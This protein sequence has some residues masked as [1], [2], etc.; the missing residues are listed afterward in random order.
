MVVARARADA[1]AAG[2]RRPDG[3]QLPQALH[4][5]TSASTPDNLMTMRHAA[6][7]HGSIRRPRRG[8]PST[9]GWRRA[10]RRCRASSRVVADHERAAVRRAAAA[11]LDIEGRPVAQGRKSARR[12]VGVVTISPQFFETVGVQ[13]RR[14]RGFTDTDGTPGA[15]TVDRQRAVRGA[16]SSRRGSDRPAHPLHAATRRA[17]AAAAASPRCGARSSASAPTIRHTN[18]AGRRACCRRSTC[19]YRQDPPAVRVAAGAQPARRR[20][21]HERGAARSAGARSRSAGL[22]HRRRWTR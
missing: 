11:A 17:R 12:E 6:A 18:A 19:P 22:D 13:L 2:R 5:W 3:A 15:E 8:A 14:G 9:I 16:S 21:D 10:W 20:R 1:G 4:D 7:R